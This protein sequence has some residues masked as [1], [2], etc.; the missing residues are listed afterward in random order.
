MGQR[1]RRLA[2]IITWLGEHR[3][4]GWTCSKGDATTELRRPESRSWS[5]KWTGLTLEWSSRDQPLASQQRI[6]ER[7]ALAADTA[8]SF[9]PKEPVPEH[10]QGSRTWLPAR[11]TSYQTRLAG[12]RRERRARAC[13][14]EVHCRDKA[15]LGLSR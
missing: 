4:C 8:D 5:S 3:D 7:T 12:G 6:V 9:Q 11:E 14:N 1:R 13:W 15:R 2:E 10:F